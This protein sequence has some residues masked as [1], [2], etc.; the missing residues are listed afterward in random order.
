MLLE[1]T[2]DFS[3][4]NDQ[5]IILAYRKDRVVVTDFWR[6]GYKFVVEFTCKGVVSMTHYA[7]FTFDEELYKSIYQST[8]L[9]KDNEV[10][11]YD[12]YDEFYEI[13]LDEIYEL[14]LIT[15]DDVLLFL[16][17]YISYDEFVVMSENDF[18]KL[19]NDDE[20]KEYIDLLLFANS[21]QP[22]WFLK[23]RAQYPK[24]TGAEFSVLMLRYREFYQSAIGNTIKKLQA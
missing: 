16:K 15:K 8:K 21:K 23:K 18:L 10:I 14:G 17:Q 2:A 7:T 19:K 4:K 20:A 6:D 22:A 12:I 1:T 13:E 9:Y 24:L 11:L 5:K 3:V